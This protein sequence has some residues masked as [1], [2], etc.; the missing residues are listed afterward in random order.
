MK[1]QTQRPAYSSPVSRIPVFSFL[2]GIILLASS[3]F[4]QAEPP[5]PGPSPSPAQ[6]FIDSASLSAV[7]DGGP[8]NVSFTT[9]PAG[10]M[11]TVLYNG[12]PDAPANAGTY[13]V[14]VTI[15]EYGWESASACGTLEISK[16]T[17]SV[18]LG[19]LSHVYDGTSKY[20]YP[21]SSAGPVNITVTYEGSSVAP[22][23]AGSYFVDA[24]IDD[25]NYEGAISGTLE[26][27]KAS[28]AVYLNDLSQTYDGSPKPAS[29]GT[30]PWVA[31]VVLTY[32]GSTEAPVD[33]GS[34]DVVATITDPNYE[35]ETT[36]ILEIAKATA[37]VSLLDL[38]QTYDGSSKG[39]LVETF[40]AGLDV[41]VNYSGSGDQPVNAGS[42]WVE[43]T[44]NDPNYEG[45]SSDTLVIQKA[46]AGVSIGDLSQTYDGGARVVSISTVPGDLPVSVTYDGQTTP[47]VDTGTYTVEAT[48]TDENYEGSA[49][50]T[51]EVAKAVVDIALSDL[52]PVYDG[53]AK[54]VSV[55]TTPAGLNVTLTYEGSSEAPVNAGSY[56][57]VATIDELN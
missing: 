3:A 21:S 56:V 10:L 44:I 42:Y 13:D 19:N 6:V 8:Q 34:Y 15:D 37:G 54:P 50:E 35:G 46:L 45:S 27:F 39:A 18:D 51:L 41:T 26:I 28:A 29:V 7:Y 17:A 20:V 49:S 14:T 55:T 9:E 5:E 38:L 11:A 2:T 22:I 24:T 52:Q 1:K 4:L 25:P 31:N 16:A 48:I 43:A 33:A 53:S 30:S 36:G 57:V 32:N 23:D 47:P 12:S 40:P